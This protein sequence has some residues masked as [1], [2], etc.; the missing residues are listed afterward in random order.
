M[1]NVRNDFPILVNNKG[2]T[3]LDSGATS[4]KPQVVLDAMNGY[5]LLY[6]SNVG[7]GL[8]TNSIKATEAYE[9]TRKKIAQ[10]INAGRIEE[11]IFTHSA[12]GSLNLIAYA[13][14]R[15][16]I[17][18]DDEIVTTVMEHHSNFVPWQKLAE[19]NGIILKIIDITDNGT[20][21]IQSS[22][23]E[24]RNKSQSLKS[25]LQTIITKKT[26]LLAITHV[27]NVL[28]TINPLKEIIQEVKRINPNC[29]VVVDGTQAVGHIP[30]NVQE[31]GCDFYVFSGHKMLG[32][33]GVG[34]LW[35]RYELLDSMPPFEFGGSMIER[36]SLN[37]T[38]IKLPPDKFEA[39]TP[40]IAEVIG[41]G[42][43]LEYLG[44]IGINNI[45]KH[46]EELVQYTIS[47]LEK[48]GCV[49][50]GPKN[51]ELHGGAVSFSVLNKDKQPIHPHDVGEI[52]ARDNIC[53]RVGHHC[54]MPLHTRLGVSATVRASFHI[55]NTKED[56][57]KLVNGIEKV[58]K[59]FC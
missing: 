38:T 40:P 42:A 11:V 45:R 18:K 29:V 49:I 46:E 21:E 16:N 28:G 55:Y 56:V 3:Y 13:W 1:K 44:N 33:T 53:V 27:S 51:I 9:N 32:P 17:G 6:T 39:G 23:F 7:R 10:F 15:M 30:V 19:E 43:A 52:L 35:G 31:L 5:Y 25:N 2:I 59:I 58:R 20:L 14:G 47:Q 22:K 24:I 50:Y 41:L 34:V 36:V 57:D 12:T 54:A 37:E 26:K 8:Y 48:H 4:L